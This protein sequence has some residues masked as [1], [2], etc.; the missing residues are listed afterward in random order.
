MTR[1][2]AIPEEGN[3]YDTPIIVYR[4]TKSPCLQYDRHMRCANRERI[5]NY[6]RRY[7]GVIPH[8]NK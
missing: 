5:H 4:T 1:F 6:R 3:N 2:S 8:L 7:T